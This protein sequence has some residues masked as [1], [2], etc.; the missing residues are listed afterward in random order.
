MSHDEIKDKIIDYLYEADLSLRVS[1]AYYKE[2]MVVIA[3]KEKG[4][5]EVHAEKLQKF[6]K[7]HGC[8]FIL[9]NDS[10]VNL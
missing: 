2:K 7:A 8:E 4:F 3:K 1:F 6:S 9:E 5:K 10:F